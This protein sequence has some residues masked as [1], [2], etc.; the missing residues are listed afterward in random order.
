M[1]IITVTR[2]PDSECFSVLLDAQFV[3]S[4]PSKALV[5]E[6]VLDT[7]AHL[8]EPAYVAYLDA[9]P[10]LRERAEASRLAQEAS[11]DY[12]VR[13]PRG[14]EYQAEEIVRA[15]RSEREPWRP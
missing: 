14:H 10:G 2:A 3:M 4:S 6:A 8:D 5:G 9:K 11:R 15:A 12:E 13:P 1:H 7:I